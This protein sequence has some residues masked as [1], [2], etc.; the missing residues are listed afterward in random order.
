VL[1]AYG[2]EGRVHRRNKAASY[3]VARLLEALRYKSKGH[4]FDFRW[5]HWGFLITDFFLWSTH[6]LTEMNTWS[7]SWG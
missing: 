2:T 1:L 5:D 6:P 7:I 3:A 4:G